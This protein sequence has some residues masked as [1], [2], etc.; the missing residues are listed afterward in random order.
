MEVYAS[1]TFHS[2]HSLL[3]RVHCLQHYNHPVKPDY[4]YMQKCLH[5]ICP[6]AQGRLMLPRG[7]PSH[8]VLDTPPDHARSE[9]HADLRASKVCSTTLSLRACTVINYYIGSVIKGTRGA[10]QVSPSRHPSDPQSRA[11]LSRQV[12]DRPRRIISSQDHPTRGLQYC[13]A[14]Y[15]NV[16]LGDYLASILGKVHSVSSSSPRLNAYVRHCTMVS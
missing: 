4:C 2:Q 3:Q 11:H 14:H 7:A 8:G 16:V 6:A 1:L 10:L 9:L 5:T 13:V 15:V 12:D